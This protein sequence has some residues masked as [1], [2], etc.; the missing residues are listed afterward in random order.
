MDSTIVKIMLPMLQ[1]NK[2]FDEKLANSY[3]NS[4]PISS[5]KTSAVWACFIYNNK[6][7]SQISHHHKITNIT[8]SP[9]SLSPWIPVKQKLSRV[10]HFF[11]QGCGPRWASYHELSAYLDWFQTKKIE[12]IA[13]STHYC[14]LYILFIYCLRKSLKFLRSI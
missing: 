12:L 10:D 14:F 11:R 13:L 6:L 1:K 8:M 9:R 5:P 2:V 7:T 4:D 3:L